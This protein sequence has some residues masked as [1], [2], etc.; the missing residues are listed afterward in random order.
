MTSFD[1][2]FLRKLRFGQSL[3]QRSVI[4]TIKL[5]GLLGDFVATQ[6]QKVT[7]QV[8]S[9]SPIDKHTGYNRMRARLTSSIPYLA[10]VQVI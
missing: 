6:A 1:F 4:Y 10:M 8:K 7:V 5:N 9:N 2:I 3:D